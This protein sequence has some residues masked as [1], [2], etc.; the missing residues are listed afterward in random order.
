MVAVGMGEQDLANIIRGDIYELQICLDILW[1]RSRVHQYNPLGCVDQAAVRAPL[2]MY[3]S[4]DTAGDFVLFHG[5]WL[6][7]KKTG[8]CLQVPLLY[9]NSI[10]RKLAQSIGSGFPKNNIAGKGDSIWLPSPC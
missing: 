10:I 8:Q 7:F 1:A 9:I 4:G 6:G 5:S 2:G 3:K